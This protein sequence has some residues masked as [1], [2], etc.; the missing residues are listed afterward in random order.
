M[1]ASS[2]ANLASIYAAV[3]GKFE[4]GVAEIPTY[5]DSENGGVNIGGT[6]IW[7]LNAGTKTQQNAAWQ[8]VKYSQKPEVQALWSTSTG[9]VATCEG[10]Y[11]TDT[12]KEKLAQYPTYLEAFKALTAYTPTNLTTGSLFPSE[13]EARSLYV[14]ALQDVLTGAATTQEAAEKLATQINDAISVYY[15][16]Q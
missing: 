12:Y 11:A 7:V 5:A 16:A 4:V 13:A 1:T 10:A 15:S 8:F 6:G 2:C 14:K 9:Y 3:D